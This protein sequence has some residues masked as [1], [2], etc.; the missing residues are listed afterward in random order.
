MQDAADHAAVVHPLFTAYVSRQMGLD[1][2]PL[3]IV[4]PKQV[5]PHSLL[6]SESEKSSA[7]ANHQ[8]I[9]PTTLLLGCSPN[10]NRA[11]GHL[12]WNPGAMLPRADPTT[13]VTVLVTAAQQVRATAQAKS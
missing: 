2:P 10:R 9:Q 8:P 11:R 4:Q 13:A 12:R 5:A 6:C 1:L 7:E 3:F